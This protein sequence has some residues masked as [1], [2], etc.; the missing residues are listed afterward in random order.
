[1]MAARIGLILVGAFLAVPGL[2]F[3]S[4]YIF[5]IPYAPWFYN[6]HTLPGAEMTSGLVGAILGIMFASSQLRPGKLN[7]P[8][9]VVCTL[10]AAGLLVAPFAKQLLRGVDYS[11]LENR[12][13]DGICLQTSSYTCVP[14]CTA[15][16]IRMQGGKVTERELARAA[17]TTQTGT[18]T[19]YMARALKQWGYE[20]RYHHLRS[21]K[22]APVPSIIGVNLGDI[23]HVVVLLAKDKNGVTIGEPLRGRRTYNWHAFHECYKLDGT[24]ITI[25]HLSE[26]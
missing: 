19:W 2:L 14:A 23:G 24:C 3:V 20:P 25:K 5:L 11:T 21:I 6:A 26:H 18:E 7:A 12:W 1:M 15:T 4:N 16:L 9:L 10:I 8:I 17:G 13:E 22:N